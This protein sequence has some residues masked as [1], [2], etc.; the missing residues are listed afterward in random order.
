MAPT[1]DHPVPD[2]VGGEIRFRLLTR[3]RGQMPLSPR[4][5]MAPKMLEFQDVKWHLEPRRLMWVPLA[6]SMT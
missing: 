1:W 3:T 4:H 2:D 5:V 6:P